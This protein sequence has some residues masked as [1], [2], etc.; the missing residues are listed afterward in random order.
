MLVAYAPSI[1]QAIATGDVSQM[2]AML[3][4]AEEY[5]KQ[6]GDVRSALDVLKAEIAKA[7]GKNK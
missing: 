7:E 4:N 1:H 6:F 2:K 5:L 3:K